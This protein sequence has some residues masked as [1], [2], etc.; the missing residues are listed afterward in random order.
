[1]AETVHLFLK[2]NGKDIKGQSFQ[3]SMGRADS[4]ECV[5]FESSMESAREAASGLATGRRQHDPIIVHKRIDKATPLL[6]KAL[7]NNEGC[8]GQFKFYRPNQKGDGTTEQFFTVAFKGGRVFSQ[9]LVV[10]NTLD[11]EA[12]NH[13]PLEEVSFVFHTIN[14]TYTDGGITHEDSWAGKE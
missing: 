10:S 7:V 9:K 2:A 5:Y 12:V 14:W 1:M 11:K 8:E 6:S 3:S 13:P 4:I